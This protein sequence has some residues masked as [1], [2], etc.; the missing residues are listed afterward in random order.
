[1]AIA[2]VFLCHRARRDF[3]D[4]DYGP[5]LSS[6][7]PHRSGDVAEGKSAASFEA[8]SPHFANTLQ[9]THSNCVFD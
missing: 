2:S 9:V 4:S 1:M 3:C 6:L 8:R 7:A 5:A